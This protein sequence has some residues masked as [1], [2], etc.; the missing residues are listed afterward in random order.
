[1]SIASLGNILKIFGGSEPTPEERQQVVKETLL[2]TLA[3]ATSADS[4]IDPVEVSAVQQMIKAVT[5]DDVSEGDVRVAAHSEVFETTPLATAL[6]KL[7]G[8]LTSADK[9]MI[10]TSLA[11]IIKADRRVSV[12]EAEFFDQVAGALRIKPSE[13]TGLIP[14]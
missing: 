14:Q 12:R 1:M 3:R 13:L 5:G 9:A 8:R 6:G 10:A 11:T 4:N 7:S 2:M